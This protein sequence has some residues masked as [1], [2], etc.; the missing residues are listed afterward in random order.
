MF[1]E[2]GQNLEMCMFAWL[3]T[4]VLCCIHLNNVNFVFLSVR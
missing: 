3:I 4:Y 1:S 2:K